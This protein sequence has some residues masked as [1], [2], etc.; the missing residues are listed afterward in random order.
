MSSGSTFVSC[1]LPVDYDWGKEA[2]AFFQA[3]PLP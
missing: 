2:I 3:H 1:S